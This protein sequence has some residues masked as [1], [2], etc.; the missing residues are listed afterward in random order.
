MRARLFGAFLLFAV[1]AMALLVIPVGFTL[2]AHENAATL[3]SLERDTRSVA[4]LLDED[5]GDGRLALATRFAHSYAHATGRQ[6]LVIGPTSTVLA[7]RPA[8]SRDPQIARVWRAAGAAPVNGVIPGTALEGPQYYVALTLRHDPAQPHPLSGVVLVV[9]YPVKVV[10]KTIRGN[11]ER[12]SLFAGLMLVGA[13]ALGFV[14]SSSLTRS[15]RRIGRA[16]EA[17]GAGDLE[18]RAPVE[19]GPPELRHL[20]EAINRTAGRLI[21]LLEVQRSFVGD[22]S[23]QL[24]TPLT[25]LS[26]QLE[27]LQHASRVLT[28]E[29]FAPVLAELDRLSRLVGSLLQLARTDADPSPPREVDLAAVAA[30]RVHYWQPLAEEQGLTLLFRGPEHAPALALEGVVE[31]VVDNLLANAFEATPAPGTVTVTVGSK[32][33]QAELHV[34][35]TGHGLSPDDRRRALW[36]FWRGPQSSPEGSGLGLAIVEQLV[37]LSGGSVILDESPE[38]GVD[39][40]VTLPGAPSSNASSGPSARPS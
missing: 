1:L 21:D 28:P 18:T 19:E 16:V 36:R 38:G 30:E 11:W 27:N 40:H 10:S 33:A 26:L 13:G 37:R 7:T 5:L 35:D 12:L 8:Q 3:A 23:H 17:I 22:A 14:L 4:S 24:R 20:A 2:D 29:D 9:T 32:G 34:L 39:A 6:I 31:Q 25:A 15:V